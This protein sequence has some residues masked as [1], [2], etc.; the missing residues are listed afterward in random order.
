ML[1]QGEEEG[2]SLL[3]PSIG[4]SSSDRQ[5]V[6]AGSSSSIENEGRTSGGSSEGEDTGR[7]SA[8]IREIGLMDVIHESGASPR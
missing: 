5:D 7:Q 1:P 6:M 8:P 2:E 3:A 4:S